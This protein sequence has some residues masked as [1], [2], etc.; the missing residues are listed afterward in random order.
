MAYKVLRPVDFDRDRELIFDYLV[1]TYH[2]L[3]EPPERAFDRAEE[4][5]LGIEDNTSVIAQ[6]P[7]QGTLRTELG[8]AIRSVTKDRAIYYFEIDEARREVRFLAVF[9]GDQD[10]Q[11][12][13]LRRLLTD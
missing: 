1:E 9:F 12:Y 3:G 6:R 5:I 2:Q 13:M 11:T 10:H 7:H 8:D 4:R